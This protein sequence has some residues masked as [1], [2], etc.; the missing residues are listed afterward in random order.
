MADFGDI[1]HDSIDYLE[2][3]LGQIFLR[4]FQHA[5]EIRGFLN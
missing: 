5:F 2:K 1:S 4:H 3:K